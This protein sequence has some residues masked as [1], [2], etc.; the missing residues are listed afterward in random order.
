MTVRHTALIR[1]V[2]REEE[3]REGLKRFRLDLLAG[4][5]RVR[6]EEEA[7][8]GLSVLLP[9]FSSSGRESQWREVNMG[10]SKQGRKSSAHFTRILAIPPISIILPHM[11]GLLSKVFYIF[12]P[13]LAGDEAILQCPAS[14]G[15]EQRRVFRLPG[16]LTLHTLVHP[17]EQRRQTVCSL[18]CMRRSEPV[19]QWSE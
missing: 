13:C 2:R 5:C 15:S 3:A 17:Q 1:R 6:R 11:K 9:V 7:R 18:R 8:Q 4:G 12:S 16:R 14:V 10:R 19:N